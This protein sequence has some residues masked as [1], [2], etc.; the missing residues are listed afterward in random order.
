MEVIARAT[1]AAKFAI[2]LES[3]KG[4]GLE[5]RAEYAREFFF[6]AKGASSDLSTIWLR[7]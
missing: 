5:V 4:E 6:G 1:G 3:F 2:M 7:D